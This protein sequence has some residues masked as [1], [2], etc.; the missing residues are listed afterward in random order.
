M[1]IAKVH[2]GL[3][4]YLV[5]GD[6]ATRRDWGHAHDLARGLWLAVQKKTG[7]DFVFATGKAHSI[8]DFLDCGFGAV[9]IELK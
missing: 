3:E 8:R 7:D 5:I 2:L 4:T 6:A 1:G 9:G